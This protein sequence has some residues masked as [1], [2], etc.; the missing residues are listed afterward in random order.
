MID[1]SKTID[2]S[3]TYLGMT[4]KSPL[5]ASS[6]PM[7][8][9][10]GNIRRMEDTGA[11]A[12]VLHSL[13][14]EQIERESDDLDRFIGNASDVSAEAITQFPEMTDAVKGPETY[15]EHLRKCKQAVRIP[16]IASLNGTTNG[17]WLKYAK[18]ME[19]AG[20]DALELNIYYIP[21]SPDVNGERVERQYVELV[22]AVRQE[23]Q[24]P[25]AVKL[26]P[27]F[28]SMA[29]MAKKL[30]A[31]GAGSLVLFNRFY[32]PDFDLEEL[33][34]TPNLMLSSPHEL[35]LRL[36]WIAVLYGS[37]NAD[38]ALTGGVHS[39]TDVVKAMMAGAKVAMMTSALLKRGISHLDT[40]TNELLIWMNEHEYD[41]VRQMRGSMSRNAAPQPAA[42]ERVNYMKMLGSYSMR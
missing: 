35:L 36:H 5:V 29:N 6:S 14:E 9:D 21:V 34:V 13:F 33:E 2:L 3:T 38:L 8:E 27:Y 37:V 18:Q 23:V 26:G 22:Q 17:G 20:A 12:V 25:V 15:L 7:C 16:V 4:L 39:A 41:S 40:V 24:I 28:S 42:F 19:Q 32:Q 11:G 10:V 30:D 1:L 31:A